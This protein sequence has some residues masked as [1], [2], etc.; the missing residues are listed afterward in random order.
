MNSTA[1]KTNNTKQAPTPVEKEPYVK[2]N[3]FYDFIKITGFV[4]TMIFMRPKVIC[5]DGVNPLKVKGGA[6]ISCNHLSYLDPIIV[7]TVF[8]NRRIS[9]IS[10]KEVFGTSKLRRGFFYGMHAIKVDRESFSMQTFHQV[11]KRLCD[12]QLVLIFPEGQINQGNGVL[13]FKSGAILMAH[14]CNKPVIPVCIIKREKLL[15]RQVVLVGEPVDVREMCGNMPT[16]VK[17]N[18]VSDYLH[19]KEVELLKKYE[20]MKKQK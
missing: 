3:L 6:L 8:W 13:A 15:D 11:K 4:P 20:T 12:D 19:S 10:T 9:S 14:Q 1:E 7:H 2:S 17:L 18:E 16:M 5:A